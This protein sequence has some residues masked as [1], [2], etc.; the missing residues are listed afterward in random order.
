M[1]KSQNKVIQSSKRNSMGIGA[2]ITTV[3]T[4]AAVT[5]SGVVIPPEVA[6]AISSIILMGISEIT[7]KD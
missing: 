7:D 1:N 3:I 4:W 6:V 2:S 5:F